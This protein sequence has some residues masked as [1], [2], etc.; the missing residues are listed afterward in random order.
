MSKEQLHHLSMFASSASEKVLPNVVSSL[1]QASS[2][3]SE[4]SGDAT[5]SNN[6]NNNTSTQNVQYSMEVLDS[7]LQ[8]IASNLDM[9]KCYDWNQLYLFMSYKIHDVRKSFGNNQDGFEPLM[10][11]IDHH[12]VKFA[13]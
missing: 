2:S 8:S 12:L 4:G 13:R 7:I 11:S 10:Q 9:H 1:Q 6:N 3:S 5:S